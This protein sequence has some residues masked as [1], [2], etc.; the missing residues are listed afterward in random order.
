MTASD[1]QAFLDR[2]ETDEDWAA[3]FDA[4]KDDQEAVLAKVHAAGYDLTQQEILDAFMDRYGA[5]LTPEQLDQIAAGSDDA[6]VIAGAVVGGVVG[7]GA[8]VAVCAAFAA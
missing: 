2:A 5:E 8:V 6:G 4:I 1:A 3:E 7:V